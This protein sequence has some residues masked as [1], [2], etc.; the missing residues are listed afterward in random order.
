MK[1]ENRVA[2]VT[3]GA[4]GIGRAMAEALA[5]E[6]AAV[7]IADLS[8]A[9]DA[10]EAI[11]SAGGRAAGATVDIASADDTQRMAALAVETFGG[12]DVLV[13][14]AGLYSSLVPKP[15]EQLT[16]DEWRR[17]LDVNVIGTFHACRAVTPAMRARGGGRIVN[18]SSGTPFKGVPFLLHYVASKG[19]LNAM[20]RALAKEL[21]GAGILVNGIAPGFTMSDGVR[22]NPVQIERLQ[23]VSV[24]ARVLQRDQLPADLVGAAVFFAGPDSSF[25]TGQ[26]LV[27]DGGAYF[28]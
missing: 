21:G 22:A 24:K 7:V 18:V 27:V 14:N 10:A 1:L 5:A 19:A 20:T 9:A 13:N 6:G 12:I 28:N 2:I 11:R 15:F 3:G 16:T 26:T 23:E 4:S 25:I 17:L 8:G